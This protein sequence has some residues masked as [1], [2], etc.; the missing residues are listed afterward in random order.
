MVVAGLDSFN[1]RIN[2]SVNFMNW[3]F[4]SWQAR[5][6]FAAGAKVG[7]A[8][9]QGGSEDVVA[10]TSPRQLAVTIPAGLG[11]DV[12]AKVRYNG[13]LRAPIAKGQHVADLVV[14]TGTGGEQRMPLVAAE[15]VEEAGF[16]GRM[17]NGLT[18]LF[19]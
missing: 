4:R 19:A 2:E 7:E 3:G 15:A 6:L 1:G 18:S 13:P 17:W 5:P 9:V 8:E 14:T 12:R 16:F 10:L 11:A